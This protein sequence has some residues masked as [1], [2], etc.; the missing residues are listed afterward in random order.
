MRKLLAILFLILLSFSSYSQ[1][2]NKHWIPPLHCRSN[3]TVNDHYIYLSTPEVTPF[4]VTVTLGNGVPLAGSPFTLSQSNPVRI[5][6]GNSQPSIMF[7]EQNNVNTVQSDKG[8]ILQ[9]SKDFYVS[10]RVQSQNHA[11]I[12]VPKGRTAL[13]TSFRVG[14]LPQLYDSAIRNF[15][16]SFMATEDNTTVYVSDYGPGVTFITPSGTTTV[17]SQTFTLNKGQSVVL[18]G[19]TDVIANR[20]GFI[21]ALLTSDKPIVVNT[22]NATGGSGPD[23]GNGASG[24]DFNLDQIVG[25]N[26]VGQKYV[27][28]KG[29]G[30]NNSELP[31]V[32][33]TVDNTQVFVNGNTSPITTLNTGEYFT[34][35][36]NNY[37]GSGTNKNMY[38]ESSQPIYLY[39]ILAGNQNDATSGLNFIPPLSCY[40]QKS[41]NMIPEYNTIGSKQYTESGVIIV[42][43]TGS[44]ITING[45]TTVATP[46]SVNG[47]TGWETYRI[48]GLNG[49]IAVESTGAL[50]VGIFGSDGISAGYGGYYSGFGSQPID[51]FIEVCSNTT[52]D[53]Y[54]AI[55]GNPIAGGTWNPALNSGTNLFDPNIDSAGTYE[56]TYDITCDGFTV[57]ETVAITVTIQTAPNAGLSTSKSYCTSDANEDLFTLLGTSDT[58]GTW[59]LNGTPRS[60]GVLNPATDVSGDYIYTIETNGA[61]DAVTATVS[62]TINNLPDIFS[63]LPYEQC[64]NNLD[65]D[66]T[67]GFTDFILNSRNNE[68]L[69]G[70]A[71]IAITYHTLQ[72]E[73]EL[74]TNA[75]PNNYYSNSKT[76]YVRLRNTITNCVA[77]N[78]IDLIVHP[79]PVIQNNVILKQ[80]DTDNDAVTSF[81]LTQANTIISTE[82]N[83]SFTYH[84][85]QIG[86]SNNTNIIT[87]DVNYIAP[88]GSMVWARIVNIN[89]CYRTAQVNLVVSATTITQ[90]NSFDLYECDDFIDA[91]D[92]DNDGI[93]Y[94]NLN[95]T[96]NPNRDAVQHFKNLFPSNQN[97]TVTFFENETDALAEMNPI[98]DLTNF[99]NNIPTLQTLWVRIDSNLNNECFGLGPYLNLHVVAIP[100][101]NLGVDFALCV[102]PISGLGSQIV[103]AT[104]MSPGNYVYQWSPMNASLDSLGNESSQFLITE[105]GTYSV[106]V[107]DIISGCSNF[108]TIVATYSSEPSIFE[109]NVINPNFSSGLATIEAFASG[110]F[111]TYEYSLDQI[112]WQTSP[113][114]SNLSN[115][116]YT[117]YVRDILGCG[118]LS[119]SNLYAITYPAFFTPNGD[120][121]NDTWNIEN[122]PQEYEA[123]LYI[124][125]RYGKL[126][127]QISPY[128][129]G[130]N[131]TF[132]NQPLP[133][134]DYWFKLEYKENRNIKEFKSH[135]SLK[136]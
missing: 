71:N 65:G 9:A 60:N 98:V 8:L 86:A 118:I 40:W 99:R 35:P 63:V 53:L 32:I 14:S 127:K 76:I 134:S 57:T 93:D 48:D 136:R 66:D 37:Q 1:L 17:T 30:S 94:F 133:S 50:A 49:D 130:W 20:N 111:G 62:V 54:D 126:I 18:S 89:N 2:S 79:L 120:G 12:L 135:F 13:G 46:Q 122:L 77:I 88:N 26:N 28:V 41:V 38:I 106:I 116:S 109:A 55:E 36:T 90:N 10:F 23:P 44:T 83:V 91:N 22:G 19:Y 27:V 123:K 104:P 92:P 84:T 128:G 70:Q 67:N 33:A 95:D 11:E 31:L 7:L 25:Y 101:L 80:C 132:N 102:D 74:G 29:N 15:V 39:Q 58:S 42:T 124:F 119:I 113:T 112:T 47:N 52:I 108:D 103:D 56:Y 5:T 81:N 97:L 117:V 3:S 129:E 43:E 96:A 75:L 107:T 100:E 4:Q 125:D 45:T 72:S 34:I 105:E 115:G 68:I 87:D 121:Y 131:G 78:T 69:Q 73:A 21:G 114:F 59:S 82:S 64:D 24:Q 51:T 16:T 61:C 6:I 110:G 85:S